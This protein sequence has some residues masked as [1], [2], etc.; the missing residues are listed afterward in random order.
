M[1]EVVITGAARTPVGAFLGGLSTIPAARL[2]AECIK[3]AVLRSNVDPEDVDQVI[4]GNVLSAGQGQAPARQAS[5]YAGLPVS[6]GALT[7]NKMCGSG[8]KSVMLASQ[9]IMTGESSVVVAGGMESMS[10][11]PFLL[12]RA[13]RGYRLGHGKVLDHVIVDGLW[14]AYN[15]IHMGTCAELLAREHKITR[16]EQD[17]FALSSYRRALNA[18]EKGHFEREIIPIEVKGRRGE[19]SHV[20]EDEEPRRGNFDQLRT[21][22]PAFQEEGSVTAGNSSKIN[23][24]AATLVLMEKESAKKRG[25]NSMARV[26]GFSTA[27]LDPVWFT[28]A[29]I[30]AVNRLL[31]DLSLSVDDIDLWEI[32][33]AFAGVAVAAINSLSLDSEKVNVNGGAVALGHPIGASGARILTTLLYAM[34]E[35]N[36]HRG[37]A[38]LCIGGG[39]AVALCI[40]RS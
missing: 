3:E 36:L 2:G 5:I 21:L 15:D 28:V 9:S 17:D 39:E 33:E 4:M 22:K 24:G 23:D 1:N 27:S 13:R 26:V 16:E 25:I 40:E 19:V 7:V 8:L 11:A 12:E 37:V 30:K 20:T 18:I 38:T 34:E 6:T 35:R 10:M 29:P 14:D 32:N 31:D